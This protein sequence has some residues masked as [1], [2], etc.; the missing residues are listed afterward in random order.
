MKINVRYGTGRGYMVQEEAPTLPSPLELKVEKILDLLDHTP[1]SCPLC[2][3][4]DF[5]GN[6]DAARQ[7]WVR[8]LAVKIVRALEE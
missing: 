4:D 6:T 8:E 7:P 3:C 5:W 2:R 1:S